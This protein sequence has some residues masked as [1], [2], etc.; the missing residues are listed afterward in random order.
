MYIIFVQSRTSSVQSFVVHRPV[1]TAAGDARGRT[2]RTGRE[3]GAGG[4]REAGLQW[5]IGWTGGSVCLFVRLSVT[6]DR[7]SVVVFPAD[8]SLSSPVTCVRSGTRRAAVSPPFTTTGTS[9]G[10]KIRGTEIA[11]NRKR[12]QN[13]RFCYRRKGKALVND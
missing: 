2:V 12:G 9:R 10:T 7:C 6:G 8:F 11:R 3:E 4:K 1:R 5:S 13:C